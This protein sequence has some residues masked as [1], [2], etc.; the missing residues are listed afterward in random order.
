VKFQTKAIRQI[1]QI[2]QIGGSE[3]FVKQL[4]IIYVIS[5]SNHQDK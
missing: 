5:Q 3:P 2:E 1:E 4:S